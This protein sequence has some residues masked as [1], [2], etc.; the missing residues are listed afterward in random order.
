MISLSTVSMRLRTSIEPGTYTTA[1]NAAAS[2]TAGLG[3]F[4]FGSIIDNSGW[5]T[6]YFTLLMCNV[7]LVVLLVATYFMI[8]LVNKNKISD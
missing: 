2:I 6:A 1:V 8:K 4:I 7:A 3:P 5:G